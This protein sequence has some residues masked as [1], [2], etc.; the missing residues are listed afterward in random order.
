MHDQPIGFQSPLA[1]L[2]EAF[3][4]EKR[5]CGYKYERAV[6][7]LRQL[8]RLWATS[9]DALPALSQKW[10]EQFFKVR[11][12]ESRQGPA[13]R[14]SVWRELARHAR[15]NGLEAY[16]P[17]NH[18]MPLG[19]DSYAPFIFTRPQIG[20]ILSAF[21]TLPIRNWSPRRP[22]AMGLLF[23]LLYGTGMRIGEALRLTN[24]DFDPQS[25]VLTIRQ[26]KNRRDRIVPLAPS[27]AN[28]FCEYCQCYPGSDD[29]PVFLSPLRPRALTKTA[30]RSSFRCA[31]SS[32]GLPPRSRGQGPRIHD[33]RHT[34]AVHRLEKWYRAGENLEA[35]LPILAAYMG[36]THMRETFYYLRITGAFFPEISRRLRAFTGEIIPN[37]KVQGVLP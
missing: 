7:I 33:L 29:T 14:A 8:D 18:T 36:H 32:A 21:D 25:N 19:H 13:K 2:I 26:G 34:F 1:D 24:G 31:L 30:V 15:R 27:V 5:A 6:E 10:A 11:P 37:P 4:R 35:K 23:R 16:I 9:K 20:A 17:S 12:G 3:V 22:W 28:R